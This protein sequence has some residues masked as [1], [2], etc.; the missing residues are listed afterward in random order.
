MGLFWGV[1]GSWKCKSCSDD[2]GDHEEEAEEE[3]EGAM[4][5]PGVLQVSG[6]VQDG[7]AD[8]DR[9]ASF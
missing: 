6:D 4:L 5:R 3:Q 8:R 2:G 9:F 7:V 1:S